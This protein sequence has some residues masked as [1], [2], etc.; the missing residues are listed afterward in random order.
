M[1]AN[2]LCLYYK[3]R[4]GYFVDC[5]TSSLPK[6]FL[7]THLLPRGYANTLRVYLALRDQTAGK[8]S[9]S[10]CRTTLSADS[11]GYSFSYFKKVHLKV[12]FSFILVFWLSFLAS[13]RKG[14][15]YILYSFIYKKSCLKC[16]SEI[17]WY[18]K[19]KSSLFTP[20]NN[21]PQKETFK[22]SQINVETFKKT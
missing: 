14:L 21:H 10:I 16:T 2:H 15:I 1:E 7:L 5:A 19:L 9:V 20:I 11:G 12:I 4:P 3:G 13:S 6:C 8:E 18:Y 22:L 17:N